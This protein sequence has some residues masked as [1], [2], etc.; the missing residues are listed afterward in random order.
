MCKHPHRDTPKVQRTSSEGGGEQL[1]TS[2]AINCLLGVLRRE[3]GGK[4]RSN[5]AQEEP[6][7]LLQQEVLESESQTL[8]GCE[9][10]MDD[11]NGASNATQPIVG[12]SQ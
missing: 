7:P 6:S 9:H 11:C 10:Y 4:S 2:S 8:P 3:E 12:V 5:P 1:S